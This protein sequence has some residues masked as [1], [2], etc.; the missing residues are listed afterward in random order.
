MA[1]AHSGSQPVVRA[2][3]RGL[4]ILD[5]FSDAEEPLALTSIAE[6]VGLTP[7]TTLRILATLE[8][9]AY[10]TRDPATKRYSP[11]PRVLRLAAKAGRSNDLAVIA[12]RY[13][14][15]LN[16]LFDES[17]SVYVAS[18]PYRVCLQR[19][20]S[21]HVLRRVVE[22]GDRLPLGL[23]ASGKVLTA[24]MSLVPHKHDLSS[25]RP[26]QSEAVLARVRE[27]GYATSFSEREEGVY[28][29]AAPLFATSGDIVGA[30]SL[31]GPTVRFSQEALPAMID[32]VVGTARRI[33]R[34]LGWQ[35]TEGAG[36]DGMEMPQ[37]HRNGR[38]ER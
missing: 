21:S 18:I 28:A 34:A 14:K 23:G 32:A 16:G 33:S 10:V 38:N 35:D 22:V 11:G 27:L 3:E 13:M 19:V 24:W 9:K 26:S 5:C 6:T 15:E 12:L 37:R 25:V 36:A 30:L 17:I 7:S 31:S 8:S 20:E 29:L 1:L 4:D 2:L